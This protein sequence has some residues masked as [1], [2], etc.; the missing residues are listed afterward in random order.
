MIENKKD[1][2]SIYPNPNN[3][4]FMVQTTLDVLRLIIYDV[5]GKAVFNSEVLNNIKHFDLN[6][7]NGL[8]LIQIFTKDGE[9]T[10][11]MAVK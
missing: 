7:A 8:Y 1:A 2:L 10:R 11:K 5:S 4:S 6:L 3:G 9:I